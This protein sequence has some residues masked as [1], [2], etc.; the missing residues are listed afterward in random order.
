MKPRFPTDTRYLVIG[1]G[2]IKEVV[3]EVGMWIGLII[4][5]RHINA[6]EDGSTGR[7]HKD[8]NTMGTG[9]S[10]HDIVYPRARS[11]AGREAE[12]KVQK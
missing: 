3:L 2:G 6:R 10:E 8:Y 11:K 5:C 4:Q 9:A 7:H 12:Q 1:Q